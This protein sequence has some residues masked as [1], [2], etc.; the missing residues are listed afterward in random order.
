M[1][2]IRHGQHQTV[3]LLPL[4][5]KWIILFNYK[6]TVSTTKLY[7]RPFISIRLFHYWPE[8]LSLY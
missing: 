2:T 8:S 4:E 1:K 3:A 5:G 6:V 7:L